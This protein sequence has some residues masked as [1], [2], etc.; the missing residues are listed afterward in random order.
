MEPAGTVDF[1]EQTAVAFE[2]LRNYMQTGTCSVY[3][4]SFEET[5]EQHGDVEGET[6]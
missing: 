1:D 6:G 5:A 3:N 4:I 2:L